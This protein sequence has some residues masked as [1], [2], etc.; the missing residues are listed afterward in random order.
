[1]CT[2]EN[3]A[4]HQSTE[5]VIDSPHYVAFVFFCLVGW[6]VLFF[7]VF[8]FRNEVLKNPQ[9]FSDPGELQRNFFQIQNG[10]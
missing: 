7:F 2:D 5:D 4:A 1:M 3:Q 6:L 9:I 8:F 10:D